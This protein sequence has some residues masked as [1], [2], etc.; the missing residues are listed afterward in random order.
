MVVELA[1]TWIRAEGASPT[2][3]AGLLHGILGSSSNWK[4]FAGRLVAACPEWQICSAIFEG[5]ETHPRGQ[6]LTH[7]T[8]C[9]E[10]VAAW[11][12]AST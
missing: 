3:S 4:S 1:H 8:P 6:G 5:T 10:D 9:A 12:S 11:S 7:S 2:R